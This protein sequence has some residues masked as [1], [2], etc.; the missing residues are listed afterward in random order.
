MIACV[1]G[2]GWGVG[3]KIMEEARRKGKGMEGKGRMLTVR[4]MMFQYGP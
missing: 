2:W 1:W 3:W 4:E